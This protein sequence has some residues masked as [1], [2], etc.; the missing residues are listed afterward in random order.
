MSELLKDNPT[1]K[2]KKMMN[3]SKKGNVNKRAWAMN[4]VAI[5]FRNGESGLNQSTLNCVLWL[6]KAAVLGHQLSMYNAADFY[7]NQLHNNEKARFWYQK[8]IDIGHSKD[9]R[10]YLNDADEKMHQLCYTRALHQLQALEFEQNQGDYAPVEEAKRTC[11]HCQQEETESLQ[12]KACKCHAAFY[13][14]ADCQKKN[15]TNTYM[16]ILILMHQW[17]LQLLS[18]QNSEFPLLY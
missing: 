9:K 7:F 13:C 17:A 1:K 4:Q 6:E 8:C 3:N 5:A 16:K 10:N 12:L 11:E 15:W 2:M 14:N 18:L